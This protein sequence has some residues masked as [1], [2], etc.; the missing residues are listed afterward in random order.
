[1]A[2]NVFF[3]HFLKALKNKDKKY[4]TKIVSNSQILKYLLSSASQKVCLPWN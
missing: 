4:P 3:L 2:K 1:M